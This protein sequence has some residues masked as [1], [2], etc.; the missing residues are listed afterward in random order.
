V[1]RGALRFAA[2]WPIAFVMIVRIESCSNG[3]SM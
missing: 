1:A 2:A 3:F